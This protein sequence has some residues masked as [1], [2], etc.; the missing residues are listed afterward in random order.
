[1]LLRCSQSSVA[2]GAVVLCGRRRRR[3]LDHRSDLLLLRCCQRI[4]WYLRG[5][6]VAGN[7]RVA[8]M[9][10]FLHSQGHGGGGTSGAEA[11]AQS[12]D[13]LVSKTGMSGG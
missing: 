7:S 5:H 13:K 4:W 2:L 9:R 1:M 12:P 6:W 8:C 10:R 3:N 11:G